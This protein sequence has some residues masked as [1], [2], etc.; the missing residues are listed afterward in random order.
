MLASVSSPAL[1]TRGDGRS[2][3]AQYVRA[4]AAGAAGAFAEANAAYASA[5]AAQPDDGLIAVRAFRQ[6]MVS[7]DMQL[8]LRGAKALE[9]SGGLPADGRLLLFAQAVLDKK[10]RDASAQ[11]D[12]VQKEASFDFLVPVLRAWVAYGSKRGDPIELLDA[13]RGSALASAYAGEHRALMLLAR[14]KVDDGTAAVRS[15]S[16]G[17][18]RQTGLR[19]AAAARLSKLRKREAA[20]SLLAG[21]A[22]ALRAARAR[23]E[24]G[25]KLS[26]GVDSAPE[27]LAALFVRLAIDVNQ[28]RASPLALSLA[29]LATWLDP[30]SGEALLLGAEMLNSAGHAPAALA[31]LERVPADSAYSGAAADARVDLLVDEGQKEAALAA[32]VGAA[33]KQ[34]ASLDDVIRAAD[35]YISLDRHAEAAPLYAR[36]IRM[37][38]E[39]SAQKDMLWRLWLVHGGA[40][41]RAGQW[42]EALPALRKAA[43]LAPQEPHALNYLGY[44]QLE[45]RENMKEALALVARASALRPDDPAITDS[46]GWGYYLSGDIPKAIATLERAVQGEPADPTINE[47]LG[48]AYWAAGRRFEARYAWR[49]ASIYAEEKAAAR[50]K[51]KLD[52]GLTAELAAP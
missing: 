50:L 42:A 41:E 49:A 26:G 10:W 7:G 46:L 20:L 3:L 4:R 35:L 32:A 11:I 6:G 40:L 18:G 28:D 38:G 23:L 51:A 47:H 15:L 17:S 52:S 12:L 14:K 2:E 33:S 9:A 44:A 34:G 39:D 16:S 19:I 37:A 13:A 27:G 1:A 31:L 30:D 25:E 48:D 24:A 21:E 22:P 29:R 8:A 43:E 5:L 45:R 36:A